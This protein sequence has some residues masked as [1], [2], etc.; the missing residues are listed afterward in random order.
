M[1]GMK[2]IAD[3]KNVIKTERPQKKGIHKQ[4]TYASQDGC[5]YCVNRH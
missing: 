5:K 2:F 4:K 1:G 3:N